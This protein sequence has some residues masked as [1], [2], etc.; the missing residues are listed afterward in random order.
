MAK[1]SVSREHIAALSD[2][3]A[4]LNTRLVRITLSHNRIGPQ[5]LVLLG[6]ALVTN[7]ALQFLEL[8]AC[9]LAGSAYRPQLDGLLALS[10]GVQSARSS[11][12]SLNVANNDLQPDGCRILLGALAFH[13]T[14]TALDL[15]NNMLSLFNDRQGYL[16]LASLLQ[17]A[18]GLCWL[19]ISENPLPRHAEPVL[20]R[21]L[22]AN[23]SLTS[24]DASHCG[25]SE[26]QL[27]LAQPE[28]WQKDA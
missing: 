20:Q 15:S 6:K 1:R 10:K 18:R 5:G 4:L 24:L 7:N 8:E 12:R 19:S 13:P 23:A 9:E 3:L 16:A 21:A 11:L 26:L 27:R 14:L 28:G 22:A 25:I 2:F 17:F